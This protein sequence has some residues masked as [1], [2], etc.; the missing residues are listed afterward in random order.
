MEVAKVVE[1]ENG[2]IIYL[3]EKFRLNADEVAVQPL[4]DAIMLV[5]KG[6]LR[7]DS[8]WET[9]TEGI[10]SFTSDVFEGGRSQSGQ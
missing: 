10:N 4:G 5:P 2:Q 7:K 1:S 9:F 8:L 3:P 6:S